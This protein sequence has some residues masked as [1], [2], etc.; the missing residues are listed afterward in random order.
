MTRHYRWLVLNDFVRRIS[1]P[2][3]FES[4]LSVPNLNAGRTDCAESENL[5]RHRFRDAAD[6]AQFSV[7]AYRLGTR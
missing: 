4:V 3:L 5:P 6:A 7:A 2:R 1:D